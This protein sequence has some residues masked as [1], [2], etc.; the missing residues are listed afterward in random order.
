MKESCFEWEETLMLSN[1]SISIAVLSLCSFL[2][3]SITRTFG[4]DEDGHQDVRS[5]YL[6]LKFSIVSA[7]Q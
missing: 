1:V 3:R 5:L 6:L 2:P 7:I 4:E